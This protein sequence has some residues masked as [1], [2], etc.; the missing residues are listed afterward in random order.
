MEMGHLMR[1]KKTGR[2]LLMKDYPSI[3]QAVETNP[4]LIE[5]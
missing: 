5:E 1:Y 4:G 3:Q 2:A